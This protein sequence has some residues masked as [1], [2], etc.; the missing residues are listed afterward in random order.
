MEEWK[1][2]EKDHEGE[3]VGIRHIWYAVTHEETA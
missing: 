2:Q 1:L 3:Q